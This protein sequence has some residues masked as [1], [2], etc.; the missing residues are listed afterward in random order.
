MPKVVSDK[1]VSVYVDVGKWSIWL[2]CNFKTTFFKL[3]F[4]LSD[5][6]VVTMLLSYLYNILAIILCE[7]NNLLLGDNDGVQ[8]V[9]DAAGANQLQCLQFLLKRGVKIT[10]SDNRGETPMHKAN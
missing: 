10:S 7:Y 9:H 8:P 5:I 1:F 3:H 4:V 2:L 6:H